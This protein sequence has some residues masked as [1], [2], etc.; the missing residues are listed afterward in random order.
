MAA[1]TLL[2]TGHAGFMRLIHSDDLNKDQTRKGKIEIKR[3]GTKILKKMQG[4]R[5]LKS[6]K[7]NVDSSQEF[8]K[9]R[10]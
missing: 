4:I 3:I 8:K 1:L 7:M 5:L 10:C 9:I 6:S 2:L